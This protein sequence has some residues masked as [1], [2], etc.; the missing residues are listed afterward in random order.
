MQTMWPVRVGSIRRVTFAV[1]ATAL[2]ALSGAEAASASAFGELEPPSLSGDAGSSAAAPAQTGSTGTPRSRATGGTD[3]LPARLSASCER[4]MQRAGMPLQQA[5]ASETE[6]QLTSYPPTETKT[7]PAGDSLTISDVRTGIPWSSSFLADYHNG[8]NFVGCYGDGRFFSGDVYDPCATITFT[9]AQTGAETSSNNSGVATIY[10]ACGNVVGGSQTFGWYDVSDPEG[11]LRS[12]GEVGGYNEYVPPTLPCPGTA[13]LVYS[14]TQTFRSGQ[15]LTVTAQGSFQLIAAQGLAPAETYGGGNPALLGGQQAC[16]ADPVNTATGDYFDTTVD[17]A[18]PGRGPGLVMERTYSSRAAAAGKASALGPGWSH[19]YDWSLSVDPSTSAATVTAG[20]GSETVF[21]TDGATYTPAPRV[22]AA[23]VK[24]AD[25]TWTYTVRRRTIYTFSSAG[26]L[27]SIADLNGE[28]TTFAYTSGRLASATDGVGRSFTFAYD[29]SGR[30]QTVSDSTGRS[31]SYDHDAAGDLTR[32]TEV[33][34]KLWDFTYD[35]QHLLL[36]RKDGRRN[37]VMTNTYDSAGRALTQKD[38]LDHTTTFV[39]TGDPATQ[40]DVTDRNSHVTRYEYD[41]GMLMRK[42]RALGTPKQARWEYTYDTRG[43]LGVSSILDPNNH[44]QSFTYDAAGNQLT[45]T[46]GNGK[47]TEATYDSLNDLLTFKDRNNVTTSY[48]YDAKGNLLTKSTPLAGTSQTQTLTYVRGT[49]AHPGD[50]TAV[51]DPLNNS[52]AFTYGANTGDLLSATD[53]QGNKTTYT[54]NARGQRLTMVSP[55]GNV[56]GATPSAFTTTYAYDAAGN[57]LTET[58]P[59]SHTVT[60]T[61]DDNGNLASVKDARNNLT[62]YEY[63]VE[64]RRTKITRADTT[65]LLEGYDPEGNL[66]SQTDGRVKATTYAYDALDQLQSTTD[67]LSRTTGLSYDAVGNL[68]TI[69]DGLSR[70]ATYSYDPADRLSGINYSDAATPDVSYGYDD[71]GRRTSMTDGLGSSSFTY[72]SLGRLKTAVDGRGTTVSYAYDLADRQTSIV[73]PGNKTA[74]RTFD[75]AGRMLTVTDWFGGKTTF[76]YDADSNLTQATFPNTSKLVDTYTFNNAGEQTGTTV[77]RGTSTLATLAYTRDNNG[78]VASETPTGLPGS[79][80]SFAYNSLN[81]LT[82]AGTKSFAYDPADN[83]TT[84]ASVSGHTYDDAN[85]LTQTPSAAYT[86]NALGQ[87]T[88][89]TPTAGAVT[90]YGWNQAGQ[91]TSSTPAGGAATSYAYDGTGLR[92]A[93]TTGQ[94]SLAFTWD[95]SADLPLLLSD[96]STS[97]VYGPDGLPISQITNAGAVTYLHHDQLGSTRLLSNASGTTIASFSY[98]AYGKLAG[99]TGTATT[100]LGFAGQYTDAETGFQYLRARYYDPATGQFVSRDPIAAQTREVYGYASNNPLNL[101]DPSGLGVLEDIGGAIDK[102]VPDP[103]SNAAA[104]LLNFATGGAAGR[105]VCQ[106]LTWQNALGVAPLFVPGVGAVVSKVGARV[107]PYAVGAV[108]NYSSRQY[109]ARVSGRLLDQRASWYAN[110]SSGRLADALS[111][112][113]G[114]FT[115]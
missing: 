42:T 58:D 57:L 43:S 68:R 101:S 111:R 39:Y 46:D 65:T 31:V 47:K 29:G 95:R 7:S 40:V 60:K 109:A 79:A 6:A 48:T 73:Y 23:L 38:G 50:V 99:S 96:G 15:T 22:L 41:K 81:Q 105:I 75:S 92:V 20:N 85:Q 86:F 89:L 17:L 25:G 14:F 24:N 51:K 27:T 66:T 77:K 83:P 28:K 44:T 4:A 36:T 61:Y 97:Y 26:K 3:C 112:I 104:G 76:G 70:T 2:L 84:F 113:L 16:C 37:V 72:D 110:V 21:T 54:Y 62:T 88:K 103:V 53:P 32:V 106:G 74:T 52:T 45:A 1:L 108:I 59:L 55:R 11:D 114:H 107:A 9:D 115:Q 87:R 10:D 34:G 78:Q 33:R 64:N 30:L 49:A 80:Q 102:V 63:D 71:N 100:A 94:N 69:T 90:D 12:G 13:T 5:V 8:Q 93:K 82:Q 98:D 56:R 67:P 35:P 19:S 91:M 18:I